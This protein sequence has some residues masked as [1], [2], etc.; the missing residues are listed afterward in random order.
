MTFEE[1]W[2]NQDKDFLK[3]HDGEPISFVTALK[4]AWGFQ[5]SIIDQLKEELRKEREVVDFYTHTKT[6][7]G[8]DDY[9]PII[10]HNY[11]HACI[12]CGETTGENARQRQRERVSFE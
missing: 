6:R 12:A 11:D 7:D 5:Q 4:M 8:W 1:W 9:E 10:G 3:K 2:L